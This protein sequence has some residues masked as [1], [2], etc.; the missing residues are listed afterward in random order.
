MAADDLGDLIISGVESVTKKWATQ[1]KAEERHASAV[2]NRRDALTRVRR[3]TIREAAFE[4][5]ETAYLKASGG[6]ALYANARQVMYAARP[7]ILERTGKD[8][9]DTAYFTQQLLP[10]YI[11][12]HDLEGEWKIAYD[13]RGHFTEPHRP[14]LSGAMTR[15]AL[16]TLEVREYLGKRAAA[17]LDIGGLPLDYPTAGPGHRYSGAVFIEKEGFDQQIAQSGLADKHDVAFMSTKGMSTTAARELIDYLAGEGVPVFVVHDFDRAGF[18]IAGTLGT[19]S[20]RYAFAYPP[21]VT[22]LGLRL[23]DVE[24]YGLDSEPWQEKGSQ[25]S[26]TSTLERHGA[27][28]AEVAFLVEGGNWKYTWGQ[29]VELNAFTTGQFIEWLDGKLEEHAPGKVV[30]GGETL[31]T[32]YR[33]AR[34]RVAVNKKIAEVQASLRDEANA[35]LVPDDLD[36]QVRQRLE[37]DPALSWDEALAEIAGDD[38]P[39]Q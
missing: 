2:R 30:P 3:I 9:L 10:D 22:D 31:A 20:R 26:V 23:A 33:R 13:A 5:M 16:G 17:P 19:S 8:T 1:R 7:L 32:A 34:I 27:T 29:R 25:G 14:R 6:G 36:E 38:R 18:T 11:A 28:P 37:D 24:E 4:V 39:S 12:E 21:D 15:A 35:E